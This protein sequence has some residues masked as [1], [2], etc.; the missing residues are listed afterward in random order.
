MEVLRGC[1]AEDLLTS[2]GL[3]ISQFR[4]ALSS[5][6]SENHRPG[7]LREQKKARAVLIRIKFS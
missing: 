3:S 5:A 7:V 4:A 6:C 1:L 2:T